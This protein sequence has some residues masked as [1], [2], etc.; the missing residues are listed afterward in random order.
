[1]KYIEAVLITIN[2]VHE[3]FKTLQHGGRNITAKLKIKVH[4]AKN[5]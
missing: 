1:M 5:K 3:H 4:K 2:D